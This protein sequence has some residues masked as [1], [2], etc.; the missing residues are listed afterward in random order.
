MRRRLCAGRAKDRGP[1][2]R[3]L[4]RHGRRLPPPGRGGEPGRG[5]P[6]VRG[7]V[8][9][10]ERRRLR[11]ARR[12]GRGAAGGRLVAGA[13]A[14]DDVGLRQ[15]GRRMERDG[16]GRRP[17]MGL[18]ADRG[19]RRSA[20]SPCRPQLAGLL[21]HPVD[22]QRVGRSAAVVGAG[23]PRR[24]RRPGRA[25]GYDSRPSR[26]RDRKPDGGGDRRARARLLRP[27]RPRDR[28]QRNTSWKR[29][30]PPA[31]AGPGISTS[32]CRRWAGRRWRQ[33]ATPAASTG[34]PSAGRRQ[35]AASG[36]TECSRTPR[37]RRAIFW[38]Q[39]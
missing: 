38:S 4:R 34:K 24:H 17:P 35:K 32:P 25:H 39:L 15:V 20:D 14:A 16:R 7:D 5:R 2:L 23:R 6:A 36:T 21:F 31:T 22:S 33:T 9:R 11:P 18:S 30:L 3:R 8:A 10:L 26:A 12:R 1:E 13:A 29:S 28:R 27:L 37:C 19:H